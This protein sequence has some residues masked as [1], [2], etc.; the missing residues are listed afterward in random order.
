MAH[1]KRA[2]EKSGECK[3]KSLRSL[4]RLLKRHKIDFSSW[5]Q[6]KSK[7]ITKLMKEVRQSE[8]RFFIRNGKLRRSTCHSQAHIFC[9]FEGVLFELYEAER[10]F[11]HEDGDLTYPGRAD[12]HAVS[13]KGQQGEDW[14]QTMVRCLQEELGLTRYR[15]EGMSLVPE[16]PKRV[17]Y[18]TCASYPGLPGLRLEARFVI[19]LP[20]EFFNRKGYVEKLPH[21][22]TYFRWR[23]VTVD[24]VKERLSERDIP[25]H[26][27]RLAA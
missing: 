5:G 9:I 27:L 8:S 7:P 22:T 2:I 11:H 1:K 21:R 15:G 23:Q 14:D 10:I 19:M 4:R 16:K 20:L 12:G 6:G 13:E 17:K 26:I 18:E 24:A 25:K 3:V